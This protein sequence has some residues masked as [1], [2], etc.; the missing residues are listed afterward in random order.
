M[1]IVFKTEDYTNPKPAF[2]RGETALVLPGGFKLLQ[3]FP[4]KF[5]IPRG[6]LCQVNYPGLTAAIVKVAKVVAG[7]TTA[8]PRVVKGTLFQAGDVVMKEGETTGRTVTAVDRS[9]SDYDVVTLNSALTG[10]A[11]DDILLEADGVSGSSPKYSANAVV[12][13]TKVIERDADET[14]SAAGRATVLEGMTY[15]VPASFKTGLT[16]KDNPNILFIYQ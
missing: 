11:A 5:V 16:L 3:S 15:P 4:V 2:W 10:L 6:T 9:N 1:G 7:G 14:I 12:E 13:S 8:A